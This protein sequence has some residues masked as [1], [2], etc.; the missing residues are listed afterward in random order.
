MKH[1]MIL[2]VMG[3]FAVVL[4]LGVPYARPEKM[5]H[6]V[7]AIADLDTAYLGVCLEEIVPGKSG[8]P[9]PEVSEGALIT[10]VKDDSP[11]QHAGL[12]EG[13]VIVRWNDLPV[14]SAR[15]LTRLVRET[16]PGRTVK[17]QVVRKGR[18]L[19]VPVTLAEAPEWSMMF[20]EGTLEQKEAIEK[21][22][23]NL[24]ALEERLKQESEEMKAQE[25][26]FNEEKIDELVKELQEEQE[27][28]RE[29]I[30]TL[31]ERLRQ[32]LGQIRV[33][34]F[35]RPYYLGVRTL[36]LTPQLAEY[37][38]VEHGVL[39]TEVMDDSPADRAGLKAGDVITHINGKA[40]EDPADLMTEL[41]K[42]EGKVVK[43]KI[44]RNH[45][46]RE[47]E[48]QLENS[49]R[50]AWKIDRNTN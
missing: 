23:E 21:L 47:V 44:V 25:K 9:Q 30:T 37:F 15:Q 26:A 39:I 24:K 50:S 10:C 46:A 5:N 27:K 7:V 14:Y 36:E 48:V 29:L 40:V 45:K 31:K 17:I 33:Y 49:G 28:L 3:L 12:K 34:R 2:P 1:K 22:K 4:V 41:M 13:D 32:N 43:L 35:V 42:T 16:P 11:A 18:R 6:P 8:K 19:T 20:R 38:G